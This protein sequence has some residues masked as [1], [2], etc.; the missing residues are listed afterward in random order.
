MEVNS[1][2][3][4]DEARKLV[5]QRLEHDN[6][7]HDWWH[8]VRVCQ[9][10]K[11]IADCEGVNHTLTIELAALFHDLADW[12]F[13]NQEEELELL[14]KWMLQHNVPLDTIN[15]VSTII[16]EISF[17]GAGVLT[18]MSTNAGKIVQDADRLDAIGA[19]GIARTFTFGGNRN[20]ILYDPNLKP[21]LH[22]SFNEYKNK[23]GTTINHFYEKLLLIKDRLNTKT[24][25]KIAEKRHLFMEDFLQNFL[26]EWNVS[27]F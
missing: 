12:K 26:N 23:K 20:R 18:P 11:K 4:L 19:I 25:K 7:G 9:L 8:I 5:K 2:Q 1:S 13:G 10:S 14:K 24:A 21:E 22:Q 3:I 15:E 27:D 17:K 6:S 16:C